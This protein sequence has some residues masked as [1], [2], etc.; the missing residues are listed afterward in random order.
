MF[1]LQDQLKSKHNASLVRAKINKQKNLRKL[2]E[3]LDMGEDMPREPTRPTRKT[4]GDFEHELVEGRKMQ[5][6]QAKKES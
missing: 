6:E 4:M 1:S 3:S 2:R 5:R